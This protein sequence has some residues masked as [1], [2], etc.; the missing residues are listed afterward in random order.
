MLLEEFYEIYWV[1][2]VVVEVRLPYYQNS[3][4]SNRYL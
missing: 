3:Y 4:C 2:Y 1:E